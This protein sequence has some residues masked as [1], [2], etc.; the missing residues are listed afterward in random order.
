MST[1]TDAEKQTCIDLRK[2]GWTNQE[3]G[4]HIGSSE[5]RVR[6]FLRSQGY[7]AL[8]PRS[9]AKMGGKAPDVEVN[10]QA[11][12]MQGLRDEIQRLQVEL[13]NAHR[14]ALIDDEVRKLLKVAGE[15]PTNPPNW[16]NPSSARTKETEVPI[17]IWSDWHIGEFVESAEVN[18]VNEYNANIMRA[19]VRRLVERTAHLAEHHHA[20]YPGIVINLLG[21]FI[22]G[23][24]HMENL[25]H[26]EMTTINS[27]L[28]A[29]D[30]LVWALTVMVER[31]GKVFVACAAGNHGRNTMRPEFKR[32]VTKNYDWM[33]YKLLERHFEDNPNIT[34][35]IPESNEVLYRVYNKRFLAMHGDMLG[36]RGG[37]GIIGAL[38][39]I[40][41]GEIKVR[42]SAI[43]VLS[44]YDM[45]LMGHWH[46]P[47]WLPRVIVA[48]SLVGYNEYAKNALRAPFSVPSQ[49]LFFVHP[50]YG[51]T[52]RWEIYLEG[53]SNHS[54]KYEWVS[55]LQEVK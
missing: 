19:R 9:Y 43:N 2:K 7:P 47:L 29:R 54:Q 4:D 14:Q 50:K 46:Q 41:R 10:N 21:D 5:T 3:I 20:D 32:Y 17:A 36:V 33:V 23:G 40:T 51:I 18:G 39:P 12:Q 35:A 15:R 34:F 55:V 1:L 8:T 38:G 13:T 31:F 11:A 16:V 37:D 52:S 48:N 6:R 30:I 24:L 44:D 42:G 28:E 27:A 25:K 49:P 45:L 26:D 53:N 22:S